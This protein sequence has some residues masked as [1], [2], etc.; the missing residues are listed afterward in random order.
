M[1]RRRYRNPPIE[2]AVCDIQFAPGIDWDP[3]MPGRIHEKLKSVYTEKPRLQQMIEAQ[4]QG[5]DSEGNPSVSIQ[6]RMTKQRVQL[7]A[8]NGTRLVGLAADQLTIHMLRPYL[9]WDEYRPRIEQALMAY[10]EVAEPEAVARIGLR[11][12]NR[13]VITGD[14]IPDL[15]RYFTVPPKFPQVDPN[16]RVLSFFNRKEAE[17]LDAPIRIVVTFA[18]ME[19]M[20]PKA[21]NYLLD[22]D[23]IWIS[24]DQPAP[25][26]QVMNLIDDMK[27]RHR[28]VFESLITPD[29]RVLF[30]G[31]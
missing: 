15:A 28:Q 6:Q 2:E 9:G 20:L 19:P 3:T 18:E 11:Y 31:G 23:I 30:D 21:H 4:L 29:A 13:I 24:P 22:L 10:V 7:L 25:L 12:I 14:G 8:E 5:A 27:V 17:Y 16:I 26:D 1:E